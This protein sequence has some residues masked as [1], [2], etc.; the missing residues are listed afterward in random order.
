MLQRVDR[1]DLTLGIG[2]LLKFF[3]YYSNKTFTASGCSFDFIVTYNQE[4]EVIEGIRLLLSQKV[5][6]GF[7]QS[8]MVRLKL[9]FVCNGGQVSSSNT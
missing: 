6:E 7:D 8:V 3:L 4:L 5:S 1:R 2:S 9:L